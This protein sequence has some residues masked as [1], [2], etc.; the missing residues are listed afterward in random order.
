MATMVL[1]TYMHVCV[2]ERQRA[3]NHKPINTK[4]QN[5]NKKQ[6]NENQ[7]RAERNGKKNLVKNCAQFVQYKDILLILFVDGVVCGIALRCQKLSK[8]LYWIEQ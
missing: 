7:K 6:Q 5:P 3:E 8:E 1:Y 2:W 4:V